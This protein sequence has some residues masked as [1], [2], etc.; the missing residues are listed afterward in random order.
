MTPHYLSPTS[1]SAAAAIV[2]GRLA[3]SY[4]PASIITPGDITT[5]AIAPGGI[6]TSA[7]TTG[8]ITARAISAIYIATTKQHH[9]TRRRFR[10]APVRKRSGLRLLTASTSV[11][12]TRQKD[13][14]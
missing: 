1:N 13:R 12:N 6:T 14:R 4:I 2:T 9:N 3:A 5:G 11:E 7:I 10:A 8:D